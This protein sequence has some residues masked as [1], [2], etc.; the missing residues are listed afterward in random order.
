MGRAK[1]NKNIDTKVIEAIVYFKKILPKFSPRQIFNELKK[2]ATRKAMHIPEGARLPNERRAFKIISDY[3]NEIDSY[4][5]SELD[6]E[7]NVG[8]CMQNDIPAAMVPLLFE[9]EQM[10]RELSNVLSGIKLTVRQCRWFSFLYQSARASELLNKQ[11]DAQELKGYIAMLAEMYAIR[12]Q[13]CESLEQPVETSDLDQFFQNPDD[14]D[15]VKIWMQT[16]DAEEFE[17]H[18]KALADFEP[19]SGNELAEK[20]DME[21]PIAQVNIFNKWFTMIY[22]R[23]SSLTRLEKLRKNYLSNIQNFLP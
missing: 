4:V 20:L 14:F 10:K 12:E 18:Q 8:L 7:W 16:V 23:G 9:F 5:T 15:L 21:L 19:I 22:S 3:K 2:P 11:F 1:G 13:L 6:A 17:K